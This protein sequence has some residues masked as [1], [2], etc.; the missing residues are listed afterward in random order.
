MESFTTIVNG[1]IIA[2]LSI[3]D[4][5]VK[6]FKNWPSKIY[7]RQPLKN[8]KLYGLPKQFLKTANSWILCP[9]YGGPDYAS[10]NRILNIPY[11]TMGTTG[12]ISLWIYSQRFY[13]RKISQIFFHEFSE[14]LKNYCNCKGRIGTQNRGTV[15]LC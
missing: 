13:L 14:R 11:R 10:D 1:F 2:E 3:W 15:K 5:W 8:L 9:K 6:V 12:L 7:G 4:I